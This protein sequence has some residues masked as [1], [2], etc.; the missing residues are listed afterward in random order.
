MELLDQNREFRSRHW[1]FTK[2]Y[3]IKQSK[4]SVATG[5]SPIVTW[6]PNQLSAVLE[7]M[8]DTYQKMK[9]E[10]LSKE[11]RS[12][13]DVLHQRATTQLEQLKKQVAD[14]LPH[15]ENQLK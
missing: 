5:G 2:E 15:Y 1:K 9:K 3:I 6:L 12:Q 11:D 4:H 10:F 14:F 8:K 13:M 7:A